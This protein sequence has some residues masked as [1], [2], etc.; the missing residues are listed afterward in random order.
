MLWLAGPVY[1][2]VRKVLVAYSQYYSGTSGFG[3]DNVDI[4]IAIVAP[5]RPYACS[6]CIRCSILV[7]VILLLLRITTSLLG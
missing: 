6:S 1:T 3:Y 7:V 5:L 4:S 2:L